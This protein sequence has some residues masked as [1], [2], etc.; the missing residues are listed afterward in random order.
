MVVG[1]G[2]R[3]APNNYSII[4]YHTHMDKKNNIDSLDQL[5]DFQ[6]DTVIHKTGAELFGNIQEP[7]SLIEYIDKYFDE[8]YLLEVNPDEPTKYKNN[9]EIYDVIRRHIRYAENRP[10]QILVFRLNQTTKENSQKLYEEMKEKYGDIIKLDDT[11]YRCIVWFF[12]GT[13]WRN[14]QVFIDEI[15][16]KRGVKRI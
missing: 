15:I 1:F 7:D 9:P 3:K 5:Q 4:Y 10:L 8:V 16:S 13:T 14:N 11:K 12:G 2:A 6:K